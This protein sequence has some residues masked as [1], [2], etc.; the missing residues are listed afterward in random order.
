MV[1]IKAILGDLDMEILS[2][3]EAGMPTGIID[4]ALKVK[5]Q[6]WAEYEQEFRIHNYKAYSDANYWIEK[7]FIESGSYMGNPTGIYTKNDAEPLYVF[8]GDDVPEDAT[9]YMACLGVNKMFNTG[10]VGQK[11]QK[12]L[13]VVEGEAG[14]YFYI[15]YTADTKSMTKRRAMRILRLPPMYRSRRLMVFQRC[16]GF[17]RRR[18]SIWC[19]WTS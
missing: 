3:A 11:L 18:I 4:I 2:M 13:N 19:L 7:L 17:W 10:K 14:K 6:T 15:L 16:L 5:N 1:E 12:G 8:V 9:L